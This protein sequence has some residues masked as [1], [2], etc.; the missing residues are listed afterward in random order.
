MDNP[1]NQNEF[2]SRDLIEYYDELKEETLSQYNELKEN[3]F[4][5]NTKMEM[6]DYY[7]YVDDI[8]VVLS[9]EEFNSEN[10]EEYIALKSFIDELES[11]SPD[12]KYGTSIIHEDY[13]IEYCKEQCEDV[14]EIPKKLPWYIA[15]HINW[16]GVSNEIAMN[17]KQVEYEGDNY[18]IR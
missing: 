8:D 3:E 15:N 9:D 12:F 4:L 13:W 6:E 11:Y 16:E 5:L 2:D 1:I 14:G 10:K 7:E 18:Y 17:Y